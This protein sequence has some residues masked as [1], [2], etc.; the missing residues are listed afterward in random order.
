MILKLIYI[1]V[2]GTIWLDL[3]I[4]SGS[5]A[6]SKCPHFLSEGNFPGLF[7]LERNKIKSKSL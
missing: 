4:A 2:K 7:S 5:K 3:K 1:F 6:E